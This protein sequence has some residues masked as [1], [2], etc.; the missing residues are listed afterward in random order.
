MCGH[1][2]QDPRRH[3]EL[4][5]SRL[6]QGVVPAAD[7]TGRAPPLVCAALRG[8]RAQLELLRDPR[9]QHGPRLGRGR[10]RTNSSSTSRSTARCRAT[11]RRSSRCRR[12][13]ATESSRRAAAASGSPPSSRRALAERV[14]EETAPLAEAG[15]LGAYL[16]QLTPAFGPGKH[17]L[18][19]LDRLAEVFA[20]H[21][22]AI[23]LRHRGW[24]RDRRRDETLG[25]FSD[26]GVAFVCVDAPPA[27][28]VPIMPS[29]LDAV[30]TRRSRLPAPARAQHGR[31]PERPLGGGALRLALHGRR[32]RRGRA[33]RAPDG[34]AGGRG[35]C[36]LQQQP[37]RRRPD[38]RPALPGPAR[39]GAPGRG[40]A[41]ALRKRAAEALGAR[42]RT[43]PRSTGP[44]ARRPSGPPGARPGRG[45][46]PLWSPRGAP[47]A[48]GSNPGPVSVT[49]VSTALG[50]SARA[51]SRRP[52]WACRT[53]FATSSVTSRRSV[54]RTDG[55]R[56]PRRLAMA[57][58]ARAAASG[59]PAMRTSGRRPPR[60]AA[61]GAR[62][63]SAQGRR[64][65]GPAG[66]ALPGRGAMR[67]VSFE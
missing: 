30:T 51:A 60:R 45:H 34:G 14:V 27:D 67:G 16:L 4:G 22:L 6:R 5:R 41:D 54:S 2:G 33:A 23:E 1:G 63:R 9:P 39:P 66:G 44:S 62:R 55:S 56:S 57:R 46:K 26:H 40:T 43:R 37:R 42:A 19:E 13:C 61:P 50:P 53:L 7:D 52:P 17:S 28:H 35:P 36:G 3:V 25:W 64:A 18:D 31:L 32:A 65:A 59:P 8:G 11:P 24:V 49:S 10:P 48:A 38:G 29:D 47:V 20:P 58:R 15:K 12:T 21:R